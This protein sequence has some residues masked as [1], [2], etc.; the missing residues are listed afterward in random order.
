MR[1]PKC[2]AVFG[3]VNLVLAIRFPFQMLRIHATIMPLT[4]VVGRLMLRRRGSPVGQLAHQA[5]RPITL[6]PIGQAA[7]PDTAIFREWPW[8]ASVAMV[9][10][11]IQQPLKRLSLPPVRG[12][13][14]GSLSW[15]M[16]GVL[17]GGKHCL[18]I[19]NSET[20]D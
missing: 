20:R 12:G 11:M 4:A 19:T 9:P 14:V 17:N 13:L 16:P 15:L 7:T 10:H 18:L 1:I 8:H 5:M 2:I 3:S 6:A